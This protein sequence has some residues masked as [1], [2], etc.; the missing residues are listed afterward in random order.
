MPLV[1]HGVKINYASLDARVR[2]IYPDN[3]DT[4]PKSVFSQQ[5]YDIS[6]GSLLKSFVISGGSIKL[7]P[8]GAGEHP[9]IA[10]TLGTAQGVANTINAGTDAVIGVANTPALAWNYTAGWLAPNI[11]YIPAPDWSKDLITNEGETAHAVS[12]GAGGIAITA[13]TLAAG[14][15]AVCGQACYGGSIRTGCCCQSC[16]RQH[17]K[18]SRNQSVV[19]SYATD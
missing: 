17:S 14:L 9:I 6:I 13:I 12:K 19:S 7:G 16:F 4:S 18:R 10:G 15:E 5:N 3:S 11:P 1:F 2:H 8:S